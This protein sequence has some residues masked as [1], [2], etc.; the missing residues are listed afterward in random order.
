MQEA[1][2][3]LDESPVIGE[4]RETRETRRRGLRSGKQGDITPTPSVIANSDLYLTAANG[5]RATSGY[6]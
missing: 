2:A 4:T 1:N 6:D 5:K 3:A